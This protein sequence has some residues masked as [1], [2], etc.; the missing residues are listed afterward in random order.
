MDAMLEILSMRPIPKET[1]DLLALASF[2]RFNNPDGIEAMPFDAA[3]AKRLVKRKL[4]ERVRTTRYDEPVYRITELG[5][6]MFADLALVLA[7]TSSMK[8]ATLLSA[9]EARKRDFAAREVLK[10]QIKAWK[11]KDR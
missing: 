10:S 5:K 9:L 7:M 11:Q 1:R 4:L 2:Q 3:A 8:P 6:L